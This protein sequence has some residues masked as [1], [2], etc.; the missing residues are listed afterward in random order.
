MEQVSSTSALQRGGMLAELRK[1][2]ELNAS[3]HTLG[4]W[5]IAVVTGASG[6]LAAPAAVRPPMA[7]AISGTISPPVEIDANRYPVRVPSK[8][9]PTTTPRSPTASCRVY[10]SRN[11]SRPSAMLN[12][13]HHPW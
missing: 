6:G 1:Q 12:R 11:I 2:N 4:G 10:A 9:S 8:P 7:A 3:R 13:L 5:Q